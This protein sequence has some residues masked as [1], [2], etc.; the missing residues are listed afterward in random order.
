[1]PRT[2]AAPTEKEIG[3]AALRAYAHDG[4]SILSPDTVAYGMGLGFPAAVVQVKRVVVDACSASKAGGF[5]CQYRLFPYIT[6]SDGVKE[7]KLSSSFHTQLLLGAYDRLNGVPPRIVSD[8]FVLTPRGWNSPTAEVELR[9]NPVSYWQE[10]PHDNSN[11]A[12]PSSSSACTQ[13]VETYMTPPY[14]KGSGWITNH[15]VVYDCR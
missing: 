10:E 3:L 13:R 15:R 5:D 14:I 8:R 4:G 1:V 6:P 12:P 9:E 2:Y 7:I 11:S